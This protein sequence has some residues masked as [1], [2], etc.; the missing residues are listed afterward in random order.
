MKGG[1][2][3]E[4]RSAKRSRVLG[5]GLAAVFAAVGLAFLV[6]PGGVTVFFN[7]LSL[8]LGMDAAPVAGRSFYL[9]LTAAYMSVVTLL[10]WNMARQPKNRAYPVL[11]AQAKLAS[12]LISFGFFAFHGPFLIYLVNGFVDGAIGAAVYQIAGRKRG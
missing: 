5:Y 4:G 12:S 9:V 1:H 3:N 8:P 7:T 6:A 11:L 10:A 2:V